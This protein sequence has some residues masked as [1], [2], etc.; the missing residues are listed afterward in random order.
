MQSSTNGLFSEK[1]SLK[2]ATSEKEWYIFYFTRLSRHAV[3]IQY[4]CPSGWTPHHGYPTLQCH[5]FEMNKGT[6]FWIKYLF[7]KYLH[8]FSVSKCLFFVYVDIRIVSLP[9][10]WTYGLRFLATRDS[11]DLAY[12]TS[13]H[14]SFFYLTYNVLTPCQEVTK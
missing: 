14:L 10:A 2:A 13:L 9:N 5:N 12:L 7:C 1:Y 4:L 3:I 11:R 8:E 6:N